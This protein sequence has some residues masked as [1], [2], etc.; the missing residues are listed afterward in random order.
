MTFETGST[1]GDYTIV[2]HIGNG[3]GGRLFKGRHKVTGRV[4]ALKVLQPDPAGARESILRFLRE[5]RL[6]ASLDHPHIARVYSAFH[7]DGHLVMAMEYVEGRSLRELLQQGP[8]DVPKA[9]DFTLQAL[10]ALAYAH[11]VEVSHRD[12]KPENILITPEGQLKLTDF[13]LA[14]IWSGVSLTQTTPPLG[15]LRYLSPEQVHASSSVDGRTDLYS[16]GVVLYEMVTG[17]PPF[18]DDKPF[19]LMKA[20]AET[21]PRPPVE[22]RDIP[23]E[24]NGA[25]LGALQKD[26]AE[27]YGSAQEFRRAL[28]RVPLESA[29]VEKP[30]RRRPAF[31]KYWHQ[32]K[33]ALPAVPVIIAI[34]AISVAGIAKLPSRPSEPI[35]PPKMPSLVTSI[36]PPAVAYEKSAPAEE[37]RREPPRPAPA[38]SES[39]RPAREAPPAPA[40]KPVVLNVEEIPEPAEPQEIAGMISLPEIPE[41]SLVPI[42]PPELPGASAATADEPILNLSRQWV[43]K[44]GADGILFSDDASRLAVYSDDGFQ[45]LDSASG[46]LLTELQLPDGNLTALALSPDSKMLVLGSADGSV[47]TWDIAAG[48]S[49]AMLGH[50]SGVTSLSLSDDGKVLAVGLR[51]R[52]VQVWTSTGDS[53]RWQ[54]AASRRIARQTPSSVAFSSEAELV[55]AASPDRQVQVWNPAGD[56]LHRIQTLADGVSAV[57]FST[58]G[59]V[60]A[61]AGQGQMGLWHVYSGQR[62]KGVST[63]GDRFA[64]TCLKTGRCLGVAVDGGAVSVWDLIESEKLAAVEADHPIRAIALSKDGSQVVAFDEANQLYQWKWNAAGRQDLARKLEPGEMSQ[65]IEEVAGSTDKNRNPFR[66]LI[67]VV[68]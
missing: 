33:A 13:G 68:R 54:R 21:P 12:I 11:A 31:G 2:A 14:K 46:E 29:P 1:V 42:T 55:T 48:R 64:I 15:S 47:R 16:L 41:P 24:L 50:P 19:E 37:E 51:D 43:A 52:N 67:D 23:G 40:A 53:S 66:R 56:E 35:P 26:P 49:T 6:Q 17:R 57:A 39:R 63:G 5:I 7:L 38:R 60:L 28:E 44:P 27:R 20:H 45:L 22:L 65:L 34:A 8:L 36:R 58:N 30:V 59:S 10:D 62:I 61:A 25:I 3:G 9:L 4:E 18:T 32:W